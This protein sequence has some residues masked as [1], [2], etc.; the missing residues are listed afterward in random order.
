MSK[1]DKLAEKYGLE[2][3]RDYKISCGAIFIIQR[4]DNGSE[5]WL[6]FANKIA[7]RYD[8]NEMFR[9]IKKEI[10]AQ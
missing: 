10:E 9:D 4:E 1:L 8:Y 7:Y 5:Y 6:F 3:Y 2:E